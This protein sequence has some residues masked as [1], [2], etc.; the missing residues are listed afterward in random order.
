MTT[1]D[2]SEEYG[3]RVAYI[4]KEFG[5]L[6]GKTISLI[7]PLM[8]AEHTAMG[9][10]WDYHSDAFI[11]VFTDDTI[12]IPSCDPEGNGAGFLFIMPTDGG[13]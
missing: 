6:R 3:K 1:T 13:E 11:I 12:V 10:E 5:S 9:W 4:E 7:R 8:P 2:V